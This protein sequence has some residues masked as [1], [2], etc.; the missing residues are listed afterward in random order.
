MARGGSIIL[1]PMRAAFLPIVARELRAASRRPQIYRGRVGFAF[2]LL[3]IAAMILLTGLNKTSP[4]LLGRTLFFSLAM[5]LGIFCCFSG[6]TIADCISQ[7]KRD[8]TLGLLFLTDLKGHDIILGKL[9]AGSLMNFY[10]L[11]AALPIMTVPLLMGGLTASQVARVAVVLL[12]TMF[13]ST[14][15]GVLVSTLS[16]KAQKANGWTVLVVAFVTAGLPALAF[17]GRAYLLERH[18]ITVDWPYL[19]PFL[20]PSPGLAVFI[21]LTGFIPGAG[22]P[23]WVGSAFWAS[24]GTT[25]LIAWAFLALA[26]WLVRRVWQDRPASVQKLTWQQRFHRWCQGGHAQRAAFRR[27]LLAVN[28]IYWLACRDRLKT[29]ATWAYPGAI[30]VLAVWLFN[31]DGFAWLEY[32]VSAPLVF[33]G[34]GAF[35]IWTASEAANRFT[36]EARIGALE[37]LLATPLTVED[38]LRGHWLA[39]RRQ[40][41]RPALMLMLMAALLLGLTASQVANPGREHRELALFMILSLPMLVADMMALGWV[42]LWQG[43]TQPL[44]QKAVG[45]T[46]FR[47][48]FLPMLILLAL[49]AAWSFLKWKFHLGWDPGLG[50]MLF[51]WS[52]LGFTADV[53]WIRWA[54]RKLLEEFRLAAMRRQLAPEEPSLWGWLGR[55]AGRL[56]HTSKTH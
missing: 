10:N 48:L 35:K 2:G 43:I 49:S 29:A 19:L 23:G 5:M 52:V 46:T 14:A 39:L 3:A 51:G 22:M 27:R 41:A 56:W 36:E 42:G 17:A 28:P 7:E 6:A 45:G 4:L 25:H 32:D 21:V 38:I 26:S 34:F 30:L 13:F 31:R 40:F 44:A 55:Q 53:L 9:A 37:L 18:G 1:K 33:Y 16:R 15:T 20:L 24:I 54:R 12:N 8:G 11:L 47:V 50:T